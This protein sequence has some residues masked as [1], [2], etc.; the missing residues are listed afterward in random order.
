[1]KKSA[2]V[3][4]CA[5]ARWSWLSGLA[6]IG[7]CAGPSQEIQ[8]PGAPTSVSKPAGAEPLA[9]PAGA[10]TAGQAPSFST[11]SASYV[12]TPFDKLP[13]WKTDNLIESWPAFLGSCSVLAGRGGEWKRVCDHASAVGLTSNDSVRAFFENEFAPYQVRDDGS[14]ADGVT[15]AIF[16]EIKGGRFA[17]IVGVAG[18]IIAFRM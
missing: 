10:N 5:R 2:V 6:L 4:Q 17:E 15:R 8:L 13:G 16:E 1:M 7:A 18:T 3:K 14:R 12:A 11:Q 9:E